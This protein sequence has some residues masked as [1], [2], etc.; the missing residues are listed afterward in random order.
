MNEGKKIFSVEVEIL[1]EM[2]K[3]NS[4]KK[5][6]SNSLRES[7]VWKQVFKWRK[8]RKLWRCLEARL[9]GKVVRD[10]MGDKMDIN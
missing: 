9:E 10:K 2:Y 1:W 3:G 5:R 6:K 7:A 4:W 8:G